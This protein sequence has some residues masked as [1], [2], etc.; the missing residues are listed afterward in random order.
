MARIRGIKYFSIKTTPRAR[1]GN[2]AQRKQ[3][4][5]KRDQLPRQ[6][7]WQT[8]RLQRDMRSIT[9]FTLYNLSGLCLIVIIKIAD[10]TTSIVI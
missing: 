2:T 10:Q 6:P 1:Q 5:I 4:G 7:R 3:R 9:L 8:L